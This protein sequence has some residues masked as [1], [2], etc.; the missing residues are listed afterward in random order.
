MIS[1][2]FQV[3]AALVL[4]ALIGDPR[5]WPH[6]VRLIGWLAVRLEPITRKSF[7]NARIAGLLTALAV[8]AVTGILTYCVYQ[9]GLI[10]NP[11]FGALV[12]ILIIYTGIAAHDLGKHANDVKLALEQGNLLLAR[13]RVGMICGRD[14]D[15]LDEPAII[16]ATVESVSEN[17]VDGVTAP[18]FYAML[19][20]PIGLMIYKAISTLDSTFGYRNERY[21]KFGW[22]SASLDDVAAFPPSRITALLI[23]CAAFITGMRSYESLRALRSDRLKHSSPNSGHSESAF[24]GALGLMLGGPSFYD[25]VLHNK[26]FIGRAIE[27]PSSGHISASVRLMRVTALI[28]LIAFA[29]IL[30]L[31]RIVFPCL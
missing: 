3:L 23:P 1:I 27:Q 14:T 4:D 19:A 22:A 21:L 30:H 9:I 24:S 25:G 26:P 5:S 2:E 12:S 7:V 6:P 18:L 16:R 8:I 31:V 20:G 13:K 11:W 29:L 15:Q 10:I 17:L 28:S